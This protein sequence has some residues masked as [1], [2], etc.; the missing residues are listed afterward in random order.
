MS[1][2]L[3]PEPEASAE[4]EDA[5]RW[6]E[7]RRAGLGLEFVEAVDA[8]LAILARWPDVGHRV[9][10]VPSD[11][12]ARRLTLSRFPYHVVYLDWDGVIRILAFA[13]DSRKPG[14]WLSRV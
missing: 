6:Y 10:S 11:I 13:H 1:R 2:R 4:F 9:S 3:R 12:P 7:S 5:V 8:A 14:Y